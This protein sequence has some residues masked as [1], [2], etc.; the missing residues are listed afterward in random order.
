MKI[1]KAVLSKG[2]PGIKDALWIK[3][4]DGG[5]TLYVQNGG[6]KPLKVVDDKSTVNTGDDKPKNVLTVSNIQALTT[7]QCEAL[8]VGDQVIKKTSD[9]RHLYTVTYKENKQGMCLTYMDAENVET[10]AYDWNGTTK[11]WG[12]TDKTV[13]SIAS[14]G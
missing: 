14:N 4:V 11:T 6:W 13:T 12:F 7:K 2:A 10:I 1:L 8:N 3:P 9:Q 5:V